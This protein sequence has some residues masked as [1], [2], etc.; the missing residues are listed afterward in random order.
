MT[1][2]GDRWGDMRAQLDAIHASVAQELTSQYD[3]GKHWRAALHSTTNMD[4][5]A[6]D[7][8]G[9]GDQSVLNDGATM[10]SP[11]QL[12]RTAWSGGCDFNPPKGYQSDFC[13]ACFCGNLAVVEQAIAAAKALGPDVLQMLLETRESHLRMP[14][15]LSVIAGSRMRKFSASAASSSSQDRTHVRTEQ[16]R[17]EFE[18]IMGDQHEQVV[19]ALLLAGCRT[20]CCDVAGYSPMH[21]CCTGIATTISMRIALQLAGKAD[22]NAHNRCGARPLM[23]P[24]M[25]RRLDAIVVLL[26]CG[27]D[28]ALDLVRPPNARVP[29]GLGDCSALS[30]AR[31]YPDAN[32]AM[33]AAMGRKAAVGSQALVARRVSLAGLKTASLNGCS[34]LVGALDV[35]SGRYEVALDPPDDA[36]AGESGREVKVQGWKLRPESLEGRRVTLQHLSDETLNG[37]SGTCGVRRCR[38]VAS[39][40]P[41]RSPSSH[42]PCAVPKQ[43]FQVKTGRYAIT[44]DASEAAAART[45]AVRPANLKAQKD[46]RLTLCDMCGLEAPK[47]QRCLGCLRVGYCSAACQTA[48]WGEHKAACKR[49]KK[50]LAVFELPETSRGPKSGVVSLKVQLGLEGVFAAQEPAPVEE[51]SLRIY[52]EKRSFQIDVHA[53]DPRH[54]FAA[55]PQYGKLDACVREHGVRLSAGAPGAKAYFTGVIT[56][57]KLKLDMSSPLPPQLW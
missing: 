55:S 18:S 33:R 37:R 42:A 8:M 6:R 15:L 40:G 22:P 23:E 14:P 19:H 52:D 4:K 27:A 50:E 31:M 48:A 32:D 45:L 12:L 28:P 53:S 2:Q 17:D 20:D 16:E 1:F 3:D 56:E 36:P 9:N 26:E 39:T 43:A 5:N 24:T 11:A 35:Q 13:R 21:H 46:G 54:G 49:G 30:L 41:A 51:G 34:G 47:L 10:D 29:K 44:L 25:A 7:P 57:G 38:P